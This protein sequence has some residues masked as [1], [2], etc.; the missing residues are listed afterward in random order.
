MS[1]TASADF[2]GALEKAAVQQ[3]E[4]LDFVRAEFF[5]GKEDEFESRRRSLVKV[6][7]STLVKSGP[8]GPDRS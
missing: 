7:P 8:G 3:R 5:T 6:P 1:G 4:F 2:P